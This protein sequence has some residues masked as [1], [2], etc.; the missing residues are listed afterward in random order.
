MPSRTRFR[1]LINS[2]YTSSETIIIEGVQCKK[3][4]S[5]INGESVIFPL[6]GYIQGTTLRE[7]NNVARCWTLS[8]NDDSNSTAA[9]LGE[10]LEVHALQR[11]L[12]MQIRPVL[13]P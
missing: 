3:F 11:Y 6:A 1:E 13:I 4:V 2:D 12:G 5:K 10:Q 7:Q 9:D 8:I